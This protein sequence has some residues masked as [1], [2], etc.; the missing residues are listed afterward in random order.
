V[1][2]AFVNA[3]VTS[4]IDL[5]V[6]EAKNAF[7]Q[8]RTEFTAKSKEFSLRIEEVRALLHARLAYLHW[9]LE[10]RDFAVFY[11]RSAADTARA[12]LEQEPSNDR[13]RA[14]Q[15]DVDDSLAYYVAELSELEP[16]SS[17]LT[18]NARNR[19]LEM[20][21]RTAGRGDVSMDI[22]TVDTCL[23]VLWVFRD[24][25]PA[26]A[27]DRGAILYRDWAGA[28]SS[29]RWKRR[30]RANYEKYRGFYE[31][32]LRRASSRSA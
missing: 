25:L 27:L 6:A 11:A 23:F 28:L 18:E 31:E 16:Q 14:F 3:R 1:L 5:R 12:A 26:S 20:L 4:A 32:R 7:D 15:K 10:D 24:A 9:N 29:H 21:D 2:G 13:L 22:E 8:A 19:S 17:A 30:Q